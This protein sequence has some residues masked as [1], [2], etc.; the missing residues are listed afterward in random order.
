MGFLWSEL[1]QAV[2]LI[3]HG[4]AYIWNVT[5]VTLRLALVST[6]AATVIGLPFAV[7]LGLGRF[8][9][10]R[11]LQALANASLAL[12]SVVVGVFV[13]ILLLP[14]GVL[15]SLRIEFSLRGVYIAQTLLAL[16]FIVALVAAAI[17]GLAPGLLQQARALGA[18]RVQLAGLAL[19]EARIGVLAAVIAAFGSAISEVGAV[20]IVGGNIEGHDQT[21]GSAA[22]QQITDNADYPEAVA[23]GLV[24]LVLI[25]ILI[26][27]LTV[28]QQREG[29]LGLRFRTGAAS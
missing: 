22:L 26:A 25:G 17:Q 18:G 28:L 10:R 6:T 21:L 23:I 20:V 1:R 5:W 27:A 19:R 11:V 15:G 2:P 24:L 7:T 9:G 3:Y 13:L 29:G 4:D 8:R 14:G 16:P 12:P